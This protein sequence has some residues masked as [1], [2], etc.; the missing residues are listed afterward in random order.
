MLAD[1]ILEY[2]WAMSWV[3][4]T[5]WLDTSELF[6]VDTISQDICSPLPFFLFL[7]A[8]SIFQYIYKSFI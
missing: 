5:G 1:R 7:A 2:K 4:I 6:A 3:L 8:K